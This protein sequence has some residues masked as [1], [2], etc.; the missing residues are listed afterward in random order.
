MSFVQRLSRQSSAVQDQLVASDREEIQ[1]WVAAQ[2][3]RFEDACEQESRRGKFEA[4]LFDA[5]LV[6]RLKCLSPDNYETELQQALGAYGF[7]HLTVEVKNL[8]FSVIR[9]GDLSISA[10]W[11][12][13]GVE[14]CEAGLTTARGGFVGPCGICHED[15]PMVVL[16]PCGHVLCRTCQ[17]QIGHQCPFCRKPV[18]TTTCGLFID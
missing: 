17:Q 7:E 6:P 9:G 13:A 2:V 8:G 3:A 1:Q 12:R 10:S 4:Q 14:G 15:R 11:G 5:V 16:A 18:R